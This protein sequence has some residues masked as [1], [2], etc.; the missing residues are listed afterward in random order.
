M[1]GMITDDE[2][3]YYEYIGTL[4]EGH[5]E[6]IELGPWL[7]KSTRHI[8][9]GLRKNVYFANKT[10]HVFDDFVWRSSWMDPHI[11]QDL[12][13]PNH[14]DFRSLFEKFVQDILLDLTVNCARIADYDGN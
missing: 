13:L 7:G 10:L 6:A 11:P 9:R 12:R 8:I 5:G 14:A 3:K 2:T 1:P 4:Y